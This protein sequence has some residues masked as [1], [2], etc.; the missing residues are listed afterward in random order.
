LIL[1]GDFIEVIIFIKNGIL[2]LETY[3]NLKL[4]DLNKSINKKA[5][6]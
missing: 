6:Y 2:K 4:N 3:L 1:Q 5:T